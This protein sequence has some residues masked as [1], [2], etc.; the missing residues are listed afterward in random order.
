MIRNHYACIDN[1]ICGS[2]I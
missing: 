2:C 1:V